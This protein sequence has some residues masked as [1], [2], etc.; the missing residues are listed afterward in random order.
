MQSLL[1]RRPRPTDF[2]QD[3]KRKRRRLVDRVQRPLPSPANSTPSTAA[4]I[5]TPRTSP[6][7]TTTA[8]PYLPPSPPSNSTSNS[9]PPKRSQTFPHAVL[10]AG[11][12]RLLSA[13]DL[14]TDSLGAY[15]AVREAI[16]A[17]SPGAGGL[18]ALQAILAQGPIAGERNFTITRQALAA[19]NLPLAPASVTVALGLP[20]AE[21]GGASKMALPF[22]FASHD[23][24]AG[25]FTAMRAGLGA[26]S[27]L[28]DAAQLARTRAWLRGRSVPAPPEGGMAAYGLV[29]DGQAELWVMTHRPYYLA[30]AWTGKLGTPEFA[31]VLANILGARERANFVAQ[32]LQTIKEG[33]EALKSANE[34]P[35]DTW[36]RGNGGDTPARTFERRLAG[37]GLADGA[38]RVVAWVRAQDAQLYLP[39]DHE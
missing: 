7:T 13:S 33:R 30:R 12:I 32:C 24:L 28:L 8:L 11:Q 36:W 18:K 38:A 21:R 10:A 5:T 19:L 23:G 4:S 39:P 34:Q 35:F 31:G 20:R 17:A 15:A 25:L 27:G 6:A 37:V 16:A 3:D 2:V 22:F 1:G 14:A 9:T 26:L 29:L